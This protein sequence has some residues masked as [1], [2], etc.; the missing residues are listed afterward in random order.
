MR[1]LILNANQKILFQ[2]M[3]LKELQKLQKDMDFYGYK[4]KKFFM[5]NVSLKNSN[6]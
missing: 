5:K 3:L 4:K 1:N 2:C 6:F